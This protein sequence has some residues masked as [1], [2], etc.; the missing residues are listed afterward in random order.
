MYSMHAGSAGVV[1]CTGFGIIMSVV[2]LSEPFLQ[3]QNF[4]VREHI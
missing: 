1:N 3:V 4:P 2:D